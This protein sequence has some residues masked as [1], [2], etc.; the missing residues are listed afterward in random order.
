MERARLFAKVEAPTRRFKVSRET[1]DGSVEFLNA[2]NPIDPLVIDIQQPEM[3]RLDEQGGF[4]LDI[5]VSD[6]EVVVEGPLPKWT[7]PSLELEI[8]GRTQGK[9]EDKK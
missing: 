5:A 4:H 7:I 8:I 2:L 6:P 1:K 3:L 9:M